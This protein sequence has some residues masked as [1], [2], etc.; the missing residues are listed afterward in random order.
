MKKLICLTSLCFVVHV[1]ICQSLPSYL[2]ADGLV[3]WYPFAGNVNDESGNANHATNF[4]ATP[5]ADRHGVPNRAYKF[6]GST[7]YIQTPINSFNVNKIS[8]GIW[9][10]TDVW[11]PYAGMFCSR[12][13]NNL[14]NGLELI[15]EG[16]S[17]RAILDLMYASD[18]HRIEYIDST[19]A[20]NNWH[21][22]TGTFNGNTMKLYLDGV[23]TSQASVSFQLSVQSLFKIGTD[24]IFG[25]ERSFQGDLDDA[26]IYNKELTA[27]EIQQIYQG[28]LTDASQVNDELEITISP[29]PTSG[30][31]TLNS[32][33]KILGFQYIL[34]DQSGK[35]IMSGRIDSNST[36]IDIAQLPTSVYY[37]EINGISSRSYTILKK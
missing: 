16:G 8:F 26:F 22:I 15:N 12:K 20:D 18:F 19:L 13:G 4:G 7:N 17:K 28:S 9:F 14:M 6:N 34:R 36:T 30:L 10:K 35:A 27:N 25:T 29:N 31:L 5:T 37:F 1:S 24:D 3:A 11:K 32:T 2:P 21:F 33:D 23:L